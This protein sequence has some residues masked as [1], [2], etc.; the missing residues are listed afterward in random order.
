MK[1][2]FMGARLAFPELFEMNK[3]GKFSAAFIAPPEHP[4]WAALRD[5]CEE[6]GKAKWGAK[7]PQ[8]KKELTAGDNMLIH[9]G[10]AKASY[11]GYEGN[12][13]FNANNKVRPTV[14]DRDTSPLVA[15]DGRPYSGCYV[16]AKIDVWAQDNQYG[17]KI[18]AQLQGV[19]FVKNGDAFSKG[20]GVA[21]PATD[22]TP[23]SEGADAEDL[24]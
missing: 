11:D 16:L 8:V 15:A 5:V 23:I 3:D 22:F 19:Q 20:G 6:I 21:I 9:N 14:V 24:V 4:G 7:W 1:H 10:D 18:N 12:L 2:E 13:F 17:K